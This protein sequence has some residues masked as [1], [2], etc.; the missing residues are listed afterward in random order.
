LV[1]TQDIILQA[2]VSGL[3]IGFGYSLI[4]VGLSLIFG[5]V[6]IVNFAHGEFLM[7][8]MYVAFWAYELL[9]LDPIYA[10]PICA[11]VLSLMGVATHKLL[12]S[13]VLHA[14][15]S[16]Q[17]F[18]TFGL[19]VFLR[20]LAQFLWTGDFRY[21]G[22]SIVKGRLELF[23]IY[24]GKPQL[25]AAFV[26][27]ITCGL[28]YWFIEKTDLGRALQAVSEDPEAAS[29]MGINCERMY[30]LAWGIAGGSLGIAGATLSTFHYIFPE[31]GGS[32]LTLCFVIVALSGFGSVS[33]ALFGGVIVGLVEVLAGLFIS[34]AFK[35]AIVFLLFIAA[36]VVRPRGLFGKQ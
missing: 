27:V 25:I 22:D 26:S 35:Y 29:L 33:G 3:L 13:Q 32:F 19:L 34:P 5:V 21:I 36:I 12:I 14:P 8:G 9:D 23:G 30:M 10:L 28:I 15:Q 17:M 7:F 6:D 18:S 16:I 2:I 20:S 1:F 4:A 24:V 11:A 31:V